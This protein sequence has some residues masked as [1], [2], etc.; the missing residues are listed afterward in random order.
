MEGHESVNAQTQ[1]DVGS[2]EAEALRRHE[3]L[4]KL[5]WALFFIWVGLA[6]LGEFDLGVSL[7]GI[8]LITLGMQIVRKMCSLD[9]E[10]FW[11][12]IG[13]LFAIGGIWELS[14]TD[15]PLVPILLIIAGLL[16]IISMVARKKPATS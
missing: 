5:G 1:R 13:I 14:E 8:G 2:R 11:V 6:F 10:G 15:L 7:L 4:A 9:F 3:N 16:M 12:V